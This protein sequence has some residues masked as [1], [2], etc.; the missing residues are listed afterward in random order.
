MKRSVL[1]LFSSM[2]LLHG[3]AHTARPDAT[4]R[5]TTVQS[6]QPVP[7]QSN[8]AEDL[9]ANEALRRLIVTDPTMSVEARN[10]I[11]ATF[12]GKMTLRGAVKNQSEKQKIVATATHLSGITNVQDQLEPLDRSLATGNQAIQ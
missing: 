12:A 2:A 7:V 11:I 8:R 5:D 3:C 9:M 1:I 4:E 10:I 6:R